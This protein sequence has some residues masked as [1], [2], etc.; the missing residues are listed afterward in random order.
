METAFAGPAKLRARLGGFD[1]RTIAGYEPDEFAAVMKQSPAVH[2]FPGSMA[3]R[4]QALCAAVVADWGGDA[5]AIWTTGDP[6][7]AEILARL[8]A[9]PGFGEQ[10]AKIFLAL[11]G[12]RRGLAAPGLEAA[13]GAYGEKGSYRSVAD[14][15]DPGSLT[16]VR[17]FKKA[18]KAAAKK[19]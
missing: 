15:V 3:A 17:E 8:N 16:K 11:L 13:A 12:K 4:V 9:L 6:D 7:G 19:G 10:K 14:I 2:R 18:A 5:Q 1:A